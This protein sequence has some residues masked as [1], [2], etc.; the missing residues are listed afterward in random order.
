MPVCAR[1]AGIYIGAAL[2]AIAAMALPPLKGRPTIAAIWR[3][4]L[5]AASLPAAASLVYEWTTRDMPSHWVRAAT[6]LPLGA[7]IAAIIMSGL[8]SGRAQ[9]IR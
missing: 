1:C 6:G 5:A 2:V 7:A 4:I 9:R 8:P 3:A